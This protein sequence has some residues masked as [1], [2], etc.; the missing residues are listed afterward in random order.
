M[1]Q[2]V[3]QHESSQKNWGAELPTG[4]TS[5]KSQCSRSLPADRLGPEK[6][7]NSEKFLKVNGIGFH[8]V[9]FGIAQIL[10]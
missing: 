6:F 8:V 7:F 4:A 5:L 2:I 1:V 9:L 10:F 3:T